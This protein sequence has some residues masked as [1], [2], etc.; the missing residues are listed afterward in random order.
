MLESQLQSAVIE[1]A[2][3]L[4]WRVAH[5][6]PARIREGRVITPVQ[7]DG[8]GFPDLVLA[9]K[10]EVLFLELKRK[11]RVL[12]PEQQLWYDEINDLPDHTKRM[13]VVNATDWETG[14]IEGLLK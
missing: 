14:Y 7:A 12:R 3:R 9:R 2:R 10:G 13:Y 4:G 6:A 11:G 8:A 5:F 1:L